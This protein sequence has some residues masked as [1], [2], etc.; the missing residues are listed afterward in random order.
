[1]LVIIE[2]IFDKNEKVGL[3]FV[4]LGKSDMCKQ[5]KKDEVHKEKKKCY[6][7]LLCMYEL[8]DERMMMG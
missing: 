4:Q 5:Y 7:K 1:M 2:Y 8:Y 6:K 3:I